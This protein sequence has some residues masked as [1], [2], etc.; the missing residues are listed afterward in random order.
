MRIFDCL[1]YI[2]YV[3]CN[4]ILNELEKLSPYNFHQFLWVL[5]IQIFGCR[6][7]KIAARTGTSRVR[8]NA[9]LLKVRHEQNFYENIYLVY[10]EHVY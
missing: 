4:R 5:L 2:Q 1:V 3:Y 8:L 9:A 10:I 7:L 6:T